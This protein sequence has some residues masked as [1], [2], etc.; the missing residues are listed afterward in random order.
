MPML[1]RGPLG[2]PSSCRVSTEKSDAVR[3]SWKQAG[4]RWD[5]AGA[6]EPRVPGLPRSHP[7]GPTVLGQ[8]GGQETRGRTS[9]CPG[10]TLAPPRSRTAPP[11]GLRGLQLPSPIPGSTPSHLKQAKHRQG[12]LRAGAGAGARVRL[13]A[14][15]PPKP[16]SLVEPLTCSAHCCHPPLRRLLPQ[17]PPSRNPQG[18]RI[19]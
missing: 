11:T 5:V 4:E 6:A 15:G 8:G 7:A 2:G 1:G 13:W 18:C 10:P 17:Q 9:Q 12:C 19:P 3:E 16:P 14:G